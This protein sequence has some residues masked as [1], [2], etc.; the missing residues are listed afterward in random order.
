M[1]ILFASP[2]SSKEIAAELRELELGGSLPV[3]WLMIG[4]VAAINTASAVFMLSSL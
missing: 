1:S 4:L 2:T 3:A